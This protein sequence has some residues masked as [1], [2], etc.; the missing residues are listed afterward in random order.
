MLA[1][2]VHEQDILITVQPGYTHAD[3]CM[4]VAVFLRLKLPRK[5]LH[6]VLSCR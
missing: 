4:I 2:F 5:N 1:S 3:A 6:E